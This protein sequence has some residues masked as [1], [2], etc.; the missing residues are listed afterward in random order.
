MKTKYCGDDFPRYPSR[1]NLRAHG[2]FV[3]PQVN[4]VVLA[5]AGLSA[6]KISPRGG[7]VGAVVNFHVNVA[8]QHTTNTLDRNTSLPV[9]GTGNSTRTLQGSTRRV[10]VN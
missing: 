7:P 6:R 9:L 1:G 2:I 4:C 8:G 5:I 10:D 3:F